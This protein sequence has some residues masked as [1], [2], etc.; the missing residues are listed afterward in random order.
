M[1]R[2]YLYIFMFLGLL[3]PNLG[4]DRPHQVRVKEIFLRRTLT[5][6]ILKKFMVIWGKKIRLHVKIPGD[7]IPRQNSQW[8]NPR[9][10]KSP[11]TKCPNDK[12]P[13]PPVNKNYSTIVYK[14]YYRCIT[15]LTHHMIKSLFAKYFLHY[16]SVSLI[17]RY[18]PYM[19]GRCAP[20]PTNNPK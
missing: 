20:R 19:R 9:T 3:N 14:H 2:T 18:T 4:S 7:K 6:K 8:H 11:T 15:N 17:H 10:T 16:P 12:M 13:E 1:H 5:P